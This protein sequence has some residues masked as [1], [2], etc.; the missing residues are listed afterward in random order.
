VTG[1][2]NGRYQRRFAD[3]QSR[4]SNERVDPV[5]EATRAR[6]EAV[7][8]F[9]DEINAAEQ[10]VAAEAWAVLHPPRRRERAGDPGE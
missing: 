10:S 8:Q 3:P 6:V 4:P 1:P 7:A 9:I 2:T 5:V